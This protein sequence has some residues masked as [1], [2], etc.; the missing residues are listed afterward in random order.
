MNGESQNFMDQQAAQTAAPA[1]QP[2]ANQTT[3]LA[4]AQSTPS[5]PSD[6]FAEL[7]RL[8]GAGAERMGRNMVDAPQGNDGDGAETEPPMS[9]PAGLVNN[10][11]ATAPQSQPQQA[12][13]PQQATQGENNQ[14]QANQDGNAEGN[15]QTKGSDEA[16][17]QARETS[18]IVLKNAQGQ[19]MA[20]D[21]DQLIQVLQG[22]QHYQSQI[23][24][25][26][27]DFN[28]K[29]QALEQERQQ[30]FAE[31][32][33]ID[34]LMQSEKGFILEALESN[35][36]FAEKVADLISEQPDLLTGYQNRKVDTVANQGNEKIAE[37]EQKFNSFLQQQQQA[38]AQQQQAQQQAFID[39]TVNTVQS[40]VAQLNQRYQVPEK[41][42][43]ALTAQ[44]VLEVQGGRLSFEPRTITN[45]FENQMK[46]ISQDLSNI[47]NQVRG[48]YLSQKQSAPPPPP[49]GG[50]APNPVNTAEMSPRDRV[51]MIAGQLASLQNG[52]IR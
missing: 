4:P 5:Q 12:Q 26:Q 8:A 1:S 39:Q 17:R 10:N 41:T 36:D 28:Q 49:T 21:N 35:P 3:E 43:E 16:E 38:Q 30:I 9:L 47:K 34:S 52:T 44:A 40:N 7:K 37:L 42:I 19:E 32:S 23:D 27:T 25:I 45:W 24:H 13:Q 14:N 15:Q 33:R 22:F 20:F 2:T 6:E 29:Y 18:K 46:A 51:R 48:E 31:K 50:G 11:Y